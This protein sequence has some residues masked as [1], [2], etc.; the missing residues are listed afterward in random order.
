MVQHRDTDGGFKEANGKIP[1][2]SWGVQQ[3]ERGVGYGS[4]EDRQ[5][6][7][8]ADS[9]DEGTIKS[10]TCDTESGYVTTDL[11]TTLKRQRLEEVTGVTPQEESR[12]EVASGIRA[13]TNNAGSTPWA[14]R[15]EVLTIFRRD[16]P[17]F[18]DVAEVIRLIGT[19][20]TMLIGT[21]KHMAKRTVPVKA[22]ATE[23]EA[24]TS[25]TIM[26]V[27]EASWKW[28]GQSEQPQ[29]GPDSDRFIELFPTYQA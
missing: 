27:L 28:D 3:T 13:A 17:V 24:I 7:E 12:G 14:N 10:R 26:D 19:P 5:V 20:L 25:P 2:G 29:G 21:M 4:T 8:P 15:R 1:S 23:I 22:W 9:D 11:E 16:I 18:L 6:E